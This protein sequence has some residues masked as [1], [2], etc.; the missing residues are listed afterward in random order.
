MESYS[1]EA[2]VYQEGN[3]RVTVDVP[4]VDDPQAVL[5]K[6]GKA[7]ALEFVLYN[8][9]KVGEDGKTA[10]YDKKL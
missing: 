10:T 2:E 6:L 8:N 3:N 7:G 5:D 1:T 9:V 4:D